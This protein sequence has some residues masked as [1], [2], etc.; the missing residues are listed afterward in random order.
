METAEPHAVVPDE[1][2][3]S[4]ALCVVEEDSCGWAGWIIESAWK[5]RGTG[6]AT[7]RRAVAAADSQKCPNCGK[8]SFRTALEKQYML[9]PV[10]PPKLD[11]SYDSVPLVFEDKSD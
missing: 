8:T 4:F 5:S 1:V 9:N 2:W 3:L 11:Y 10:Q 7:D 6:G